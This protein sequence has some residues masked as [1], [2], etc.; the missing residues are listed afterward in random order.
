MLDEGPDRGVEAVQQDGLAHAR[1][2]EGGEDGVGHGHGLGQVLL[3]D[4]D[5]H[6]QAEPRQIQPDQALGVG[7]RG[8]AGLDADAHAAQPLDDRRGTRLG[9]VDR[10]VVGQLAPGRHVG[11]P[12]VVVALDPG[13]GA[14]ADQRTRDRRADGGHG[15]VDIGRGQ[16][17]AAV[18][19][20]AHGGGS[21]ARR[22]APPLPRRQRAPAAVGGQARMAARLPGAVEAGLDDH[23][24]LTPRAST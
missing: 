13:A 20:R 15:G 8:E 17:L 5:Q 6:A 19:D 9:Q 14:D 2:G 24:R 3:V 22:P 21:R 23:R 7:G 16:A 11:E 1:L 12:A 4:L 10:G 18:G